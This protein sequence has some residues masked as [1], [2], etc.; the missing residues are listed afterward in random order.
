[1]LIDFSK[2]KT[3]YRAILDLMPTN[4]EQTIGRLQNFIT[5]DEICAVLCSDSTKSANKFILD[6]LINK[7]Q[8]KQ[9]L[10]NFCAHLELACPS[11]DMLMITEDIKSGK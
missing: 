11:Q 3:H 8:T 9:H 1:M 4:Y 6:C 10:L 7:M 2:L 5:D